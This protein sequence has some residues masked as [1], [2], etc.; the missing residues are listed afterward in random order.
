MLICYTLSSFA[1]HF[2]NLNRLHYFDYFI[3]IRSW[4]CSSYSVCIWSI[5]LLIC[6]W[7]YLASSSAYSSWSTCGQHYFSLAILIDILIGIVYQPVSL[8]FL[9]IRLIEPPSSYC[10]LSPGNIKWSNT[11]YMYFNIHYFFCKEI[12]LLHL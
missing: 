7:S 1:P 10:S 9:Q 5:K 12:F 11:H 4:W 2:L 8:T 3:D 6:S